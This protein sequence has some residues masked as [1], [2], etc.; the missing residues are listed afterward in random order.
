[1]AEHAA[2]LRVSQSDSISVVEFADRKILDEICIAEIE[3]ELFKLVDRS[4]SGKL[5]LSFKN[6]GHFSSAALGM[7]LKL[8]KKVD[9]KHGLLKLSDINPQIYDVFKITQ[10]NRKF[11]IYPSADKAKASF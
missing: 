2:R 9:E 7:L 6:V 4:D 5:L 10:L 11:D 1:M 3:D 8:K